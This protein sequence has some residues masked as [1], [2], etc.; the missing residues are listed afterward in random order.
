MLT[1]KV[2]VLHSGSGSIKVKDNSGKVYSVG[3]HDL[4]HNSASPLVPGFEGK[5]Y[6]FL[7]PLVV[8]IHSLFLNW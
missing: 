2:A 7:L 8:F 3:A 4:Y 6:M 1:L 5:A